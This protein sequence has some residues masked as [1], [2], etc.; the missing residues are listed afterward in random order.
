MIHNVWI[1]TIGNNDPISSE[2]ALED[3]NNGQII[4]KS[5]EITMVLSKR[6]S[7]AHTRTNVGERWASFDQLRMIKMKIIDSDANNK[8]IS[9]HMKTSYKVDNK[10]HDNSGYK[11]IKVN[12]EGKMRTIQ[13]SKSDSK[14]SIKW[15]NDVNNE[16]EVKLQIST[17]PTNVEVRRSGLCNKTRVN[18][19]ELVLAK[20][21][22]NKLIQIPFKFHTPEHV[23]QALNSDIRSHRIECLFNCFDEIHNS[24]TL[25]CP[26]LR[27]KIPDGKKFLPTRLSFEVKLTDVLDFYEIKV[28]MCTNGSKMIQGQDFKVSYAPTV[29]ADSFRLSIALAVSDEMIIVFID[30]SNAFQTNVISDPNK[31]IYIT[32]PTMY[33]EWFQAR[34]PNHP[35]AKFKNSKELVMQSL[36]NIQGTKDAGFEWY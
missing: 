22:V 15:K 24:G 35:L 2:Q 28:R 10:E 1:L 31:R 13:D 16:N 19:N 20:P 27:I 7:K 21:K 5:I 32:L 36:R 18:Y 4:N 8:S 25:S 9:T 29:D 3:L 33:L 34:F 12:L 14:N 6:D 11:I 17:K 26:F 23:G 30:A